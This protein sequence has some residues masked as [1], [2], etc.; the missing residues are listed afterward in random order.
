MDL[1]TANS[2]ERVLEI[3]TALGS[4]TAFSIPYAGREYLVTARHLLPEGDPRPEVSIASR[5]MARTLRLDLLPTDPATADVAVAPLPEAVTPTLPLAA[6]KDGIIWGQRVFFL[7]FPY[8]LATEF[9]RGAADQRIAFVKGALFSASA[10]VEGV[11]LLYLDGMNNPGFSGGPVVFN[12]D[13]DHLR[14]HICGVIAGYRTELQPVYQGTTPITAVA[15]A[16]NTGIIIATDIRHVTN[17]ID[18]A[19]G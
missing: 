13:G 14:P 10:D 6:G 19:S 7:G 2:F 9:A 16:A 3:S 1:V 5:H 11:G 4:G 18:N 17:A 12:R 15:T 8:G